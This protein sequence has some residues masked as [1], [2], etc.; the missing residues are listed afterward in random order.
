MIMRP[1]AA[2]AGLLLIVAAAATSS[3]SP[4]PLL[5]TLIF[6]NHTSEAVHKLD[7]SGMDA[8]APDRGGTCRSPCRN[9]ATCR[10]GWPTNQPSITFRMKVDPAKQTY[11][12]VKFDGS[13]VSVSFPSQLLTCCT[14]AC[15]KLAAWEHTQLESLARAVL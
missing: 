4:E 11:L 2:D 13:A 8:A 7:A 10:S 6:G 9:A 3:W 5:D 12:T 14:R 1:V 15:I